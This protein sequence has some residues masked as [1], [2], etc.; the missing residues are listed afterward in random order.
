MTPETARALVMPGGLSRRRPPDRDFCG[1]R[2]P[3]RS[4]APSRTSEKLFS[5]LVWAARRGV[6]GG[7]PV[8]PAAEVA[9]YLPDIHGLRAEGALRAL[10]DL[11]QVG[12]HVDA[13]DGAE[14]VDGLFGFELRRARAL[15]VGVLHRGDQSFAVL[16]GVGQGDADDPELLDAAP[17]VDASR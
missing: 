5:G 7:E 4:T 17:A 9:G 6:A 3:P 14:L 2:P 12:H 13:G 8:A 15:V 10:G 11:A 16:H 1:Y